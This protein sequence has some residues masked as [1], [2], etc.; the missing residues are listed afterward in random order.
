MY[1]LPRISPCVGEGS[2]NVKRTLVTNFHRL[3]MAT[4]IALGTACAADVSDLPVVPDNLQVP[5]G[6]TLFLKTQAVGTQNYICLPSSSGFA[7]TFFSPQATVSVSLSSD[8]RQQ[9]ITHFLSP[10]PVENGTP[11]TTWQ[12]SFDTSVVWGR[13]IQNT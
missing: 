8:V 2:T 10:N 9:V 6:N 12:S 5:E 13:A 7:W 11:R 4:T 3:L 1:A